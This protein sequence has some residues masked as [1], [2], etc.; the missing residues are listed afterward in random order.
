MQKVKCGRCDKAREINDTEVSEGMSDD[1]QFG[2]LL[3]EWYC[4]EHFDVTLNEVQFGADPAIVGI[5]KREE[6]VNAEA[7]IERRRAELPWR[8]RNEVRVPRTDER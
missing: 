2:Y 5:V 7:G 1:G 4:S 3:G 6:Q 8:E